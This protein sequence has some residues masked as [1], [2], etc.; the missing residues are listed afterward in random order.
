[1]M[2]A[3]KE[4]IN[5]SLDQVEGAE[6]HEQSAAKSSQAEPIMPGLPPQQESSCE[7]QYPGGSVEDSIEKGVEFQIPK[8]C[9]GIA[10][11][12]RHMVPLEDLMKDDSVDKTAEAKA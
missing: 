12:C 9:R 8:R 1:M 11:T 4:M 10:G 7:G 2:D 5:R 3:E 6:A